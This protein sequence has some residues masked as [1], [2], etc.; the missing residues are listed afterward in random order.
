MSDDADLEKQIKGLSKLIKYFSK[1]LE[2]YYVQ[3][4]FRR[5]FSLGK[6]INDR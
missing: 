3:I 6:Q 2:K 1:D 5:C 4:G